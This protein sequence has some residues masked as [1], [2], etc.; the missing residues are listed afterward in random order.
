MASIS[1]H[2]ISATELVMMFAW[3]RGF[4]NKGKL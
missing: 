4:Y 1:E 2:V 3:C